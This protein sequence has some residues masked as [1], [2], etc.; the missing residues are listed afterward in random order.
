MLDI[1]QAVGT[2]DSNVSDRALEVQQRLTRIGAVMEGSFL[3]LCGLLE[4]AQTQAFHTIWGFGRFS[5]WVEQ[6]SGLDISAR[7]AHYYI[8]IS[9]TMKALGMTAQDVAKAKV[10]KLKV[11]LALDPLVH[12]NDMR[13]LVAAAAQGESLSSI[14]GKVREL[15]HV[16]GQPD[17]VKLGPY[18]V[19]TEVKETVD[20]AFELARRNYGSTVQDGEVCEVSDGKCLE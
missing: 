2:V 18:K 5:D 17:Y 11:I 4:E 9:K 20:E 15:R 7:S 14:E 6:G 8:R 16:A 12:A 1:I 19:Q 10:S 13:Q 3:E